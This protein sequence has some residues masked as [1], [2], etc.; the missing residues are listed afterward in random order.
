[1]PCLLQDVEK[2]GAK[3]GIVAQSIKEVLQVSTP[4]QA[5]FVYSNALMHCSGLNLACIMRRA[6]WTTTWCIRSE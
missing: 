5:H 6:W 4:G 1:M 2:L 3:K